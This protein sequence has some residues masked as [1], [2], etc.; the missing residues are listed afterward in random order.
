METG[1][2]LVCTKV[3]GG[4]LDDNGIMEIEAGGGR[5]PR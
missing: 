2:W 1:A 4:E 3:P 5:D